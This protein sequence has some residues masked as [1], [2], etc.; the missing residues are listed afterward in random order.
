[1]VTVA[2]SGDGGD[3][4]FSGYNRYQLTKRLGRLMSLV[5]APMRGTIAAGLTAVNTERWDRLLGLLP[6]KFSPP[7]AGDKVHKFASVLK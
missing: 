1:H 7:Q 3:E 5:P 2:L 6:R 4:L